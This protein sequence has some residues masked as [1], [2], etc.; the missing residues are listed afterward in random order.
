MPR[1][2]RLRAVF[3]AQEADRPAPGTRRS[4]SPDDR[5]AMRAQRETQRA[6]MQRQIA[7]VLTPA[8]MERYESLRAARDGQRGD[9]QR[10]T[11]RRSDGR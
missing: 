7:A 6:E 10:G 2:T 3:E 8:Q 4:G 5:E 1:P 9:G 11:G